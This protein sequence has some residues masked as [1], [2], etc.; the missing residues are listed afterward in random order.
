M[1]AK[2]LWECPIR[3]WKRLGKCWRTWKI[4]FK[5]IQIA[6]KKMHPAGLEKTTIPHF[7]IKIT[8]I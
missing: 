6:L 3:N 4:T 1:R 5:T 8:E 2:F 7:K